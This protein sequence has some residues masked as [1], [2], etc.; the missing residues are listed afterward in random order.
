MYL[1]RGNRLQPFRTRDRA[2][3]LFT[4]RWALPYTKNLNPSDSRKEHRELMILHAD[5]SFLQPWIKWEGRD[6][7]SR[8]W[9]RN[10]RGRACARAEHG[11]GKG[12]GGEKRESDLNAVGPKP[13]NSGSTGQTGRLYRPDR[14]GLNWPRLDKK[15]FPSRGLWR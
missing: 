6:S 11:E 8:V 12:D 9:G 2:K 14:S 10:E 13:A 15:K 1:T 4:L 5:W 3:P 7:D